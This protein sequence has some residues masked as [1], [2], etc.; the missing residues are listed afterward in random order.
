MVSR[1]GAGH[2]NLAAR[3]AFCLDMYVTAIGLWLLLLVVAVF[4]VRWAR[5]PDSKP[6]AAYLIFVVV[7]SAAAFVLFNFFVLLLRAA[8]FTDALSHPVGSAVF[9]LAVFLPSF[10][11]ARWQLRKPPMGNRRP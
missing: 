9:L 8:G 1:T 3:R 7:F 4:Y 5:H 2:R 10:L 11:I 6:V